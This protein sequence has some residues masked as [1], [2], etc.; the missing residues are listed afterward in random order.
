MATDEKEPLTPDELKR[1]DE[2]AL[3]WLACAPPIQPNVDLACPE[4]N[5]EPA[6]VVRLVAEIRVARQRIDDYECAHLDD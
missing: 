1:L 5:L 2:L 4:C 6:L 3:E